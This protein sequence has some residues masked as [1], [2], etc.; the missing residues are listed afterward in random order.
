MKLL[1]A[2]ILVPTLAEAAPYSRPL[3][4]S[5]PYQETAHITPWE[6]YT[7][8]DEK[9]YDTVRRQVAEVCQDLAWVLDHKLK[10]N[11]KADEL[12]S[13][14]DSCTAD[15]MEWAAIQ[16]CRE[17]DIPAPMCPVMAVLD[18]DVKFLRGAIEAMESGPI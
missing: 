13:T 4:L 17:S 15:D 5:N 6:D 11:P 7:P 18:M 2:L 9:D 1:L 14:M 8:L 3:D 16:A 10:G 12:R